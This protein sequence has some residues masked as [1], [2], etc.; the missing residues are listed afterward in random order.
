MSYKSTLQKLAEKGYRFS[1]QFNGTFYLWSLDDWNVRGDAASY[2]EC[3]TKI[4]TTLRRLR[5]I[6]T[7]CGAEATFPEAFDWWPVA[8]CNELDLSPV[9]PRHKGRFI[10]SSKCFEVAEEEVIK[11]NAVC[12]PGTDR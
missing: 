12:N 10:E 8:S 9:C 3:I 7:L 5:L 2:R 6:C 11:R 1:I 4:G